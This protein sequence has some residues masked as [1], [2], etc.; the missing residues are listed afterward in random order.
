VVSVLSKKPDVL[1][2]ISVDPSKCT[3]STVVPAL[4]K[5]AARC[6]G[7]FLAVVANLQ[8]VEEAIATALVRGQHPVLRH[9]K[10]RKLSPEGCATVVSKVK[11]QHS[12][13]FN[14]RRQGRAPD[15]PTPAPA[16]ASSGLFNPSGGISMW[17]H[18]DDNTHSHTFQS[19]RTGHGSTFVG[20]MND[21]TDSSLIHT[22]TF[23]TRQDQTAQSRL[24]QHAAP[25]DGDAPRC[26][27]PAEDEHHSK[28]AIGSA[29][30]GRW[31]AAPASVG[32]QPFVSPVGSLPLYHDRRQLQGAE[33]AQEESAQPKDGSASPALVE[34]TRG[35]GGCGDARSADDTA[36]CHSA[37]SV[38]HPD[39]LPVPM[40]EKPNAGATLCLSV[41]CCYVRHA[42]LRFI[43]L[44]LLVPPHASCTLGSTA[45]TCHSMARCMW[46]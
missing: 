33:D 27:F 18:A 16:A 9:S 29:P 32:R 41:L 4:Q 28:L 2:L 42:W 44:V 20:N 40:I 35:A 37:E 38:H 6:S 3:A 14:L 25:A 12:D 8:T 31:L 17:A 13:S 11:E 45:G 10:G 39:L 5:I 36:S 23:S 15:V 19:I 22:H 34:R 26:S 1:R 30:D 46:H 24:D 43:C 7:E 21:H